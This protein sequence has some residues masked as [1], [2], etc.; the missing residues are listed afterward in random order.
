MRK[1]KVQLILD[2]QAKERRKIQKHYEQMKRY[3]FAKIAVMG[4]P[5]LHDIE[6]MFIFGEAHHLINVSGHSYT[7]QIAKALIEHGVTTYD[8]PLV[9]T[10]SDMGL[11][12]ILKA[13]SILKTLDDANEQVIVHCTGGNNRSRTVVEAFYFY[14]TGLHYRDEYKGEI[15]HLIYN[16]KNGHLPEITQLEK[17]LGDFVM[18]S[19]ILI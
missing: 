13:I 19:G 9:E 16:S 6:N 18:K 2:R 1:S 3:E 11:N 4:M 5:M 15:N 10:G 14:K 7:K 8:L 17:Q 12:N